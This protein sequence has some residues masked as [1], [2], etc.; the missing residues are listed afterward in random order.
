MR[1][2]QPWSLSGLAVPSFR[3]LSVHLKFAIRRHTFN[4]DSLPGELRPLNYQ[5]ITSPWNQKTGY[6][7]SD[8]NNPREA[9]LDLDHLIPQ[10]LLRYKGS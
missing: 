3:D 8:L 1:N 10:S 7:P 5:Q 2:K 6:E 9:G 4:K